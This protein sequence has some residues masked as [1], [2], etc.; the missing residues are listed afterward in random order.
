MPDQAAADEAG[1]FN[2][3]NDDDVFDGGDAEFDAE[4]AGVDLG[5]LSAWVHG[6][7]EAGVDPATGS[8]MTR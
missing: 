6:C 1:G 3:L 5:Q 4:T 2:D 7:L 8:R